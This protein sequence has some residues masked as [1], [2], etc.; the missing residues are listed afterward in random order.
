MKHPCVEVYFDL[1]T[2]PLDIRIWLKTDDVL[3]N[4][5]IDSSIYLIQDGLIN[6]ILVMK[7]ADKEAMIEFLEKQKAISAFQVCYRHDHHRT[8]VVV[9]R[10]WP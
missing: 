1:E 2:G 5:R 8:S 9:Y 6:T 7:C 3:V 10:E 4:G